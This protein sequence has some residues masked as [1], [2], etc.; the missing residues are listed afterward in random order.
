MMSVSM[1]RYGYAKLID[2][3]VFIDSF[4]TKRFMEFFAHGIEAPLWFAYSNALFQF[5]AGVLVLAG[6]KARISAL[7]LVM[8][9]SVLTYFGHPFWNME[10]TQ[11]LTNESF[12]Y[13]N[14]AMIAAFLMICAYGPGKYTIA[15]LW[16]KMT[17]TYLEI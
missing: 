6:Y 14:I 4:I 9:L 5:S 15:N 2:I 3:H 17:K 10:G 16:R 11:R 8:W 13:R 7:L 1:I 12:F